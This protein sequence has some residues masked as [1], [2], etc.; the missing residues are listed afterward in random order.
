MDFKKDGRRMTQTNAINSHVS[1][2]VRIH[3]RGLEGTA[4][5]SIGDISIFFEDEQQLK[6]LSHALRVYLKG[7]EK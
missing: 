2:S 1:G 6:H 3:V 5:V 4:V 7:A